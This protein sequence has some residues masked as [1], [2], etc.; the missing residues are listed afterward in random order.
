MNS[1]QDDENM[2]KLPG[3][4]IFTTMTQGDAKIH[5]VGTHHCTKKSMEDVSNV[6][7]LTQPN[8]VFVELCHSSVTD[9]MICE[10]CELCENI[11]YHEENHNIWRG[12]TWKQ[13]VCI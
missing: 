9:P 1:T 10:L 11:L 2:P 7:R 6:I 5:L 4:P 12:L 3:P 13:M 8:V